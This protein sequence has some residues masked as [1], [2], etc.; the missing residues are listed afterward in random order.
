MDAA[1][2]DHDVVAAG[3]L[4][5]DDP[6]HVGPGRAHEVPARLQ[7]QPRRRPS[8]VGGQRSRPRPAGSR[9]RRGRAR[10]RAARRGCRGLRPRRRGGA[11]T[12]A[13]VASAS[14]V[15]TVASTWPA[16]AAASTTLE[17]PN[18]CSPSSSSQGERDGLA[19]GEPQVARVHPELA[20]AV[21][22]HEPD[23]L[24][25]VAPPNGAPEQDGLPPAE[26]LGDGREP[27][28][29]QRRLD[30]HDPDAGIDR[31]AQ[32]L[33]ALAR[34]RDHDPVRRHAG[35]ERVRR[36]PRPTRR[37]RRDRAAPGGA[38]RPGSGWP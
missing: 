15:S 29:L 31:G 5:V 27:A 16:S 3:Q 19:R 25:A 12:P 38:R 32:L 22:A 11:G 1:V 37:R 7:Q 2:E 10:R 28:Q 35:P 36:A 21:V 26:R 6:G 8:R 14:A 9:A 24:E 30:G 20:G 23:A 33:V 17:A 34:A 13:S 4:A 18:A